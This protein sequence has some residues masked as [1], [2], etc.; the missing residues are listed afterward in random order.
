MSQAGCTTGSMTWLPEAQQKILAMLLYGLGNLPWGCEGMMF[1]NSLC[2]FMGQLPEL[3]TGFVAAGRSHGVLS[4]GKAASAAVCDM[5]LRNARQPSGKRLQ[6]PGFP[7]VPSSFTNLPSARG[8]SSLSLA[9]SFRNR[10]RHSTLAEPVKLKL[11]PKHPRTGSTDSPY[12][13]ARASTC[14][15]DAV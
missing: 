7:A 11:G 2:G 8:T 4:A 13:T 14:A 15:H 3:A 1:W 12:Q 10:A 9:C 5:Y 6:H